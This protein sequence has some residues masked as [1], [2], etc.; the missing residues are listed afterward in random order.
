MHQNNLSLRRMT[1]L[2]TVTDDVF[3]KRNFE[4]I[5]YL[6]QTLADIKF[7]RTL[8]MDET[9]VY[10]KDSRTHIVDIQGRSYVNED[11]RLC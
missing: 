4:Y 10:F 11:H 3:I 5:T 9:A 1:N 6:H 8:L 2:A 7:D